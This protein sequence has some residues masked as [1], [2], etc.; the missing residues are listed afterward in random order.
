MLLWLSLSHPH[1][2]LVSNLPPP[3]SFFLQTLLYWLH[4]AQGVRIAFI[5][6]PP[7]SLVYPEY[8]AFPLAR[9]VSS[10]R[11]PYMRACSHLSL[12]T[13]SQLARPSPM[14]LPFLCI[15]SVLQDH[16]V[17]SSDCTATELAAP[18]QNHF[19]GSIHRKRGN[20]KE[21]IAFDCI[22]FCSW[23]LY[24]L[25]VLFSEI[26]LAHFSKYV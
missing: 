8:P 15:L 19:P 2:C 17:A 24:C 12:C 10:L 4:Y 1:P 14:P 22:F 7:T 21:K 3:W 9:P 18:G 16:W 23:I 6:A 26:I 20:R 11:P 5:W 25:C 13:A